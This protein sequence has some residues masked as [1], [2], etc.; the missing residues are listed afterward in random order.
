MEAKSCFNC[1]RV[2]CMSEIFSLHPNQRQPLERYISYNGLKALFGGQRPSICAD[3]VYDRLQT[4]QKCTRK[5]PLCFYDIEE[6]F[7]SSSE[8][9]CQDCT[10]IQATQVAFR[11]G[12]MLKDALKQCLKCS[13]FKCIYSFLSIFNFKEFDVVCRECVI[14]QDIQQYH[15]ELKARYAESLSLSPSLTH[16]ETDV[17]V[18]DKQMLSYARVLMNGSKS[19]EDEVGE[20]RTPDVPQPSYPQAVRSFFQTTM[21]GKSLNHQ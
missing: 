6:W 21:N 19:I 4:C 18:I 2:G 12:L 16:V 3:C 9:V 20:K 14:H 7:K 5:I 11:N 15:M 17:N 8:R 1:R 13:M 10:A